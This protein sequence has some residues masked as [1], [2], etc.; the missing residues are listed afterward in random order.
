MQSAPLAT[1]KNYWPTLGVALRFKEAFK[2]DPAF[3][4]TELPAFT[5]PELIEACATVR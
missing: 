5:E 2:R 4:D 1:R 3:T